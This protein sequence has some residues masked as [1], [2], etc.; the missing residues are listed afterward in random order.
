MKVI[1]VQKLSNC[2]SKNKIQVSILT[3]AM[4]AL[5][6]TVGEVYIRNKIP[7]ALSLDWLC[8]VCSSLR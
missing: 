5:M 1:F 3:M 6:G 2:H 7:E 4:F 8:A